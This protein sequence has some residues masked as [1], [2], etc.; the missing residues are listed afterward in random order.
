MNKTS[1]SDGKESIEL[2]DVWDHD[3]RDNIWMQERG[4]NKN[5]G[6]LDNKG[7]NNNIVYD[8]RYIECVGVLTCI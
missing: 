4:S 2:G 7:N 3:V 6:K 1:V 8:G 5:G